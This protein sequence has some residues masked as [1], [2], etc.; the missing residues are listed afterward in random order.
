VPGSSLVAVGGRGRPSFPREGPDGGGGMMLGSSA[1]TQFGTPD[2]GR[3]AN[4]SARGRVCEALGCS[5]ILSIYNHS[6]W[7][8]IHDQPGL[9]RSQAGVRPA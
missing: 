4:S 5:T 6:A 2:R 8:S 3:A 7:C 1:S 9:R